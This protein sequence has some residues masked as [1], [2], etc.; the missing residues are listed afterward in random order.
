MC[1]DLLVEPAELE[2]EREIQQVW[3]LSVYGIFGFPLDTLSVCDNSD[4][5]SDESGNLLNMIMD[6][7]A[8]EHVVSLA[9]WKSLGEPT[10]KPAQVRLRSATGDDMGV[11]G[12]FMVRGWCDNQMVELTALVATRATRSFFVLSDEAGERW[13]QH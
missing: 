13:L 10:L 12:C 3:A 9:D 6:S 8:E 2:G 7:G 4:F 5:P 11:S 1:V